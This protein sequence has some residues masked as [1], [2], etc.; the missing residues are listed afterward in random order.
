VGITATEGTGSQAVK[1]DTI[2]NEYD[3][4]T[5]T[6]GKTVAGNAGDVNNPFNVTVTFT[7]ATG[8]TVLSNITVAGGAASGNSQTIA[9]SDWSNGTATANIVI[10]HG[11]TVTFSNIPA[12]VSYS[13]AESTAHAAADPNGSDGSKGY[14]ISYTNE[15]GTISKNVT[16]AAAITNTKTIQI[17]TGA[18][19]D[20]LP[21]LLLM[22][23]ATIGIVLMVIRKR[24]EN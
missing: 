16:S 19:M 8:K 1:V 10:K 4:G 22:A 14:M 6:V 23:V 12:G 2:T 17:D 24:R 5:L 7:A 11:E 3:L 15:T 13:V 9:P 18:S 21:Y 20:Y